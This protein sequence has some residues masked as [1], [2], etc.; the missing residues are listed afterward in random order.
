M[1]SIDQGTTVRLIGLSG[2]LLKESLNTA[3]LESMAGRLARDAT[4]L[5]Y[6]M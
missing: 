3:V 6:G 5:G 1:M 2:S 4:L